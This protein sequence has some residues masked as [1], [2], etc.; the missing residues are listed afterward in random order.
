MPKQ[1]RDAVAAEGEQFWI[2]CRP[3]GIVC[4]IERYEGIGAVETCLE[5]HASIVR[6]ALRYVRSVGS[7]DY[8]PFG[9]DV[10]ADPFPAYAALRTQCPVHRFDDFDPPVAKGLEAVGRA[11]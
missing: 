9:S 3:S 1:H 4:G 2:A 7:T 6:V 10:L 8:N 11:S 5:F